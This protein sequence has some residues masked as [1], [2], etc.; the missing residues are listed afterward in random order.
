M[1]GVFSKPLIRIVPMGRKYSYALGVGDSRPNCS[2]KR[3]YSLSSR[4]IIGEPWAINKAGNVIDATSSF[5]IKG[6]LY[7]TVKSPI[8]PNNSLKSSSAPFLLNVLLLVQPVPCPLKRRLA[9]WSGG[10]RVIGLEDNLLIA[11]AFLAHPEHFWYK[12]RNP[13]E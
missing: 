6:Q 3:V 11:A 10:V 8:M 13:P 12:M 5:K 2:R 7:C 4:A 9:L 1:L